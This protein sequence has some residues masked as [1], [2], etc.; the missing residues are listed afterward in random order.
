MLMPM[1]PSF[2]GFLRKIA[3]KAECFGEPWRRSSP[4]AISI[5]TAC[6]GDASSRRHLSR[7]PLDSVGFEARIVVLTGF[8]NKK[9]LSPQAGVDQ[10]RRLTEAKRRIKARLPSPVLGQPRRRSCWGRRRP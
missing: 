2:A 5:S 9:S 3:K 7:H 1:A 8:G 6:G 10:S 4:R